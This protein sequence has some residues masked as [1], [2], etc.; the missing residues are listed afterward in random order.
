VKVE[1]E[2]ILDPPTTQ[3]SSTT[4]DPIAV[5]NQAFLKL[6]HFKVKDRNVRTRD[7]SL[8]FCLLEDY[9]INEFQLKNNKVKTSFLI[10]FKGLEDYEEILTVCEFESLLSDFSFFIS[11]L[12]LFLVVPEMK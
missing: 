1:T 10:V 6:I 12:I 7:L 11:E 2:L 3:H 8:V 5:Q 4:V 9:K